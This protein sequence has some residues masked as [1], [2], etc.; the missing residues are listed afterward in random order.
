VSKA[1]SGW[2]QLFKLF[3][4]LVKNK[5]VHKMS[6]WAFC[7]FVLVLMWWWNWKLLLATSAGISLMLLSYSLQNRNWQ[8]YWQKWQGFLIGSNRQLVIAVGSGGVG[9]FS[10]YLAASIWADAE[11]PW[12]A[13]GAILQ[14]FGSLT[15]LV[16]LVWSLWKKQESSTEVKLDQLLADLTNVDPLKRLIAIRQLTHLVKNGRLSQE[17]YW[18]LI[19]YYRLMLSEAQVP[20]VRNA[21]LESLD[22][23]GIQKLSPS[24]RQPV[25]IPIQLEHCQPLV[26]KIFQE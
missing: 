21:L 7:S 10:T 14:G 5:N 9:V 25:K 23:L 13:T 4:F 22:T 18:Q 12:L 1:L 24:K 15:T 19:E 26:D 11:N 2:Q 6:R 3:L 16:L 8:H 20:A 17:Y